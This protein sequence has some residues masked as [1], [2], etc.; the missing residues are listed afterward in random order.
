[1]HATFRLL[2]CK[3]AAAPT[4]HV[5]DCLVWQREHCLAAELLVLGVAGDQ[6][7]QHVHQRQR[8]VQP[9]CSASHNIGADAACE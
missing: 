8:T 1:M 9:A 4:R 3:P 6:V 5:D 2:T 7:A